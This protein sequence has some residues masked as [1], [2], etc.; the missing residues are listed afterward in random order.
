[1]STTTHTSSPLEALTITGKASRPSLPGL[2]PED[3]R[4]YCGFFEPPERIS[5]AV[6][7]YFLPRVTRLAGSTF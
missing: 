1:M 3:L 5:V 6:L 2:L 4:R 7:L